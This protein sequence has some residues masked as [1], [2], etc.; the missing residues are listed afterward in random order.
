[1]SE[2]ELT[3]VVVSVIEE[4]G[5]SNMKD[6]GSVIGQVKNKTGPS[7]DGAMIARLVKSELTK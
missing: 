4:T 3:R 1:M 2:D 7:A 6:M 5:A